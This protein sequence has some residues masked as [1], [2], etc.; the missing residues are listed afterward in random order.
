MRNGLPDSNVS[1]VFKGVSIPRLSRCPLGCGVDK[2]YAR[3]HSNSLNLMW[4]KQCNFGWA[5]KCSKVYTSAYSKVRRIFINLS[6][7]KIFCTSQG[8][9]LLWE[10][11]WAQLPQ[12]GVR[13]H[14]LCTTETQYSDGLLFVQQSWLVQ[15]GMATLS[16][17]TPPAK[18]WPA[19]LHD[20]SY[21]TRTTCP[22]LI[23]RSASRHAGTCGSSASILLDWAWMMTSAI[24]RSSSFCWYGMPWS[25]VSSTS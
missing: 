17:N 14:R 6:G 23:E 2:V 12:S 19:T 3:Q 7:P 20:R 11:D 22:G 21:P 8:F 15:E 13:E 25:P 5:I 1:T 24:R 10:S 9:T 18:C 16:L 4:P